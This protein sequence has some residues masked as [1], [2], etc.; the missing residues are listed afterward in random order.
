MNPKLLLFSALTACWA[1]PASA[2][3]K[4]GGNPSVMSANAILELEASDKG[5]LLPRVALVS[6][7]SATPLSTH[8]KGMVLYNTAAAGTGATAVTEGYYYNDGTKWIRMVDQNTLNAVSSAWL[9][10]PLEK[11]VSLESTSTGAARP[12]GTQISAADNGRFSVGTTDTSEGTESWLIGSVKTVTA[13]ADG[14]VQSAP[15]GVRGAF[16]LSN[17]AG[18]TD[19]NTY[20]A[21]KGKLD[22]SPTNTAGYAQLRGVEAA[23][24]HSGGGTVAGAQGGVFS[25]T[26]KGTGT[27]TNN[28]GAYVR[29]GAVSGTTTNATAIDAG[30]A[31]TGGAV[32]NATL[33]DANISG[34]GTT[35]Q[36][37]K[38]LQVGNINQGVASNYSI[39]TG[40]GR[41]S[42]GDTLQLRSAVTAAPTDVPLTLSATG[43][44]TKAD[45]T[46]ALKVPVGNTGQRPVTA[47]PGL[48]RFNTT[49]SH[50]EGYNGTDWVNMD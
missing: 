49:T 47:S 16:N 9:N 50:F 44:V 27:I 4:I 21:V 25:S 1:L 2:Q 40:A 43:N 7:T 26:M 31:R 22:V 45:G 20:T 46:G 15:V 39:Y 19:N 17:T 30:L 11:R 3:T 48:I 38:G 42:L 10:K 13:D 33:I 32:T 36:N 41:V 24:S 35:I 23:V 37:A 14:A 12:A 18:G 28:A 29:V 34:A 6:T 5:V 8:E